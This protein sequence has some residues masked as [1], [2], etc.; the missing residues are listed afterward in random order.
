[1]RQSR[2]WVGGKNKRVGLEDPTQT[3]KKIAPEAP[4]HKAAL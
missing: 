3:K 1:M 2:V 4:G